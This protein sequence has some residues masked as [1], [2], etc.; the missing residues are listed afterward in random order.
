LF[1]AHFSQKPITT[2]TTTT[3]TNQSKNMVARKQ[4]VSMAP[5]THEEFTRLPQKR[6]KELEQLDLHYPGWEKDYAGACD[7]FHRGSE[8]R[9]NKACRKLRDKQRVYEDYRAFT[10]LNDMSSLELGYPGSDR[11]KQDLETWHLKHPSTD[12][13][14]KNFRDKL[15]GLQNKNTLFFGD[16]S[17]SNVVTLDGLEL[18]YPGW[19]KDY[20]LAV[21]AHCDMPAGLFPNALHCLQEKQRIHMGDRSHWRL[22]ELDKIKLTYPGCENDVKEVEDWHLHNA[23]NEQNDSMFQEVVEGIRDQ[24]QIFLGWDHEEEEDTSVKSDAS[25]DA[26]GSFYKHNLKDA[27]RTQE[28]KKCYDSISESLMQHE[29]KKKKLVEGRSVCSS[30]AASRKSSPVDRRSPSPSGRTSNSPTTSRSSSPSGLSLSFRT[31]A[32]ADGTPPKQIKLGK[33]V[34]CLSRAKTHVFLP[35]GHLC[36]CAACS[37]KAMQTTSC[38]PICRRHTDKTHRVFLS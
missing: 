27:S 10:R 14:D 7:A 6:L 28:M 35:C 2:T 5:E 32:G 19:E 38:C 31:G 37:E 33:C 12:T 30:S 21:A 9:F 11:D 15:E 16:R 25:H 4:V 3:K 18:S 23:D 13:T 8:P 17:N 34:V 26:Q 20:Q 36:A 22:S 29:G 24:E 1:H